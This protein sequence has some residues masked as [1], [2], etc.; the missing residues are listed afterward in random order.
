MWVWVR[1]ISGWYLVCLQLAFFTESQMGW[2]WR[3]SR[4]ICTVCSWKHFF[5]R[6]HQIQ[7]DLSQLYC[8]PQQMTVRIS[9]QNYIRNI[10]NR[11]KENLVYFKF[12]NFRKLCFGINAK[13]L[14]AFI[15]FVFI[16]MSL[17]CSAREDLW[18]RYELATFI[19]A[20]LL[21]NSADWENRARRMSHYTNQKLRKKFKSYELL[22]NPLF[23]DFK[24]EC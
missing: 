7:S 24:V 16:L 12:L 8:E 4:V 20:V 22:W 11:T 9:S 14:Y 17:W 2:Y 18:R 10:F 21:S 15:V 23:N 5:P 6:F 1:K 19:L 3:N 13:L